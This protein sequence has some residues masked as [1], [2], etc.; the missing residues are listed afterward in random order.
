M[1]CVLIT[2]L[3]VAIVYGEEY[4]VQILRGC[5]KRRMDLMEDD[6]ELEEYSEESPPID[7][8]RK[9]SLISEETESV[10]MTRH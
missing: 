4:G 8:S 2:C 7:E 5:K 9:R 3:H 1:I 6:L 10:G